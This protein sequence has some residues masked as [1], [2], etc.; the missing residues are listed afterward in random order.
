MEGAFPSCEEDPAA[1]IRAGA[2]SC[3]HCEA[4]ELHP[5]RRVLILNRN[6]QAVSIVD[7]RKAFVLLFRDHARVIGPVDSDHALFDV[8]QW[9]S[10][11]M[12]NPPLRDVETLR[13]V[14]LAI[15]IPDVMILSDF[16]RLPTR[17]VR[18]SH[19]SIFARDDHTCQYCGRRFQEAELSIDHVIPRERGGRNTWENLVTACKS[20]NNRKANRL[21]HEAG[22]QLTRRPRRPPRVPFAASAALGTQISPAWREYLPVGA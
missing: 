10:Y 13:T 21:P 12:A 17:E 9:L 2:V 4:R 19:E 22:M 8:G 11:S 14:R 18:L 15:R 20:C 3:F 7:V 16:D 1:T 6:W 5:Q